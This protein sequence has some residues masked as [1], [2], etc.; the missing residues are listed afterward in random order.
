MALVDFP[1]EQGI[2]G[3]TRTS[4][5]RTLQIHF[6]AAP[7]EAELINTWLHIKQFIPGTTRPDGWEPI[8]KEVV[9]WD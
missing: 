1:R 5:P 3:L 6:I 4:D 2:L 9:E 7:T 8:D